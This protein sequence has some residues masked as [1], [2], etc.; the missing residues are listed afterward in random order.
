MSNDKNYSSFT[1]SK[2]SLRYIIL[3]LFISLVFLSWH[4]IDRYNDYKNQQHMLT[5]QSVKGAAAELTALLKQLKYSVSVFTQEHLTLIQ[6]LAK[7]P[8]DEKQIDYLKQH[9]SIHFPDY[10]AVTIADHQGQ[11]LIG[12]FDLTVNELCQHSIKEFIAG[13]YNYDIFIHPHVDTYHFDVMAPWTYTDN[14]H[15]GIF[16]ISVKPILLAR[17]LKN[18]ELLGHKLYLTK[19]DIHGLI[20]ISSEGARIDIK[21]HNGNFFLSN[22]D[23]KNIGYSMP[24]P[25]TRWNLV[26]LPNVELISKIRRN[27]IL[28]TVLIFLSLI[29]ISFIFYKSIRREEQL[30]LNTDNNLRNTKDKLEHTLEFSKVATWEYDLF[31]KTFTWSKHA[32]DIFCTTVP[33][34]FDQYLKIIQAEFKENFQHFFDNCLKDKEN[35]H[36]EHQI[37]CAECGELWIEISGSHEF[38]DDKNSIKLLGLVQDITNRKIVEQN[39]I[40]FELQQKDT[41]LREVHHRIKNNLQGV[42]SLLE[43]HKNKN[44]F[45]RCILDNAMSQ[46]YSVSLIHGINGESADSKI[47]LASLVNSISQAAFS[48]TGISYKPCYAVAKK[49]IINTVD[50]NTVAIALIINELIFNAIKHTPEDFIDSI[51][52]N[53]I[54]LMNDAVIEIRNQCN[55][56]PDNFDFNKGIGLGTG[57]TLIRSLLPKQGAEIRFKQIQHGIVCHLILT[58]PIL[59]NNNE[60]AENTNIKSA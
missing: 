25:G 16:F 44:V 39:H 53:I 23:L 20:E 57:L 47:E 29:I 59:D 35:Q 19:K 3:I 38:N 2:Y 34:S 51:Q 36:F 60:N 22:D 48:I 43:H 49:H 54:S 40:N 58:P 31:T 41:L 13:G 56:L 33:E 11:P 18:A 37:K 17:V 52:I 27:I 14:T 1:H 15:K 8:D 26:D 50:N 4:G 12:N 30:H 9:A 32:V 45:D 24:V 6:F 5:E 46:I 21:N 28:Q 55:T 10:F 42:I 7:N